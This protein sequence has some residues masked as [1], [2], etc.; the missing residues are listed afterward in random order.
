MPLRTLRIRSLL[1]ALAVC[2]V[3]S[4]FASSAFASCG[5]WLADHS[6]E[7][8]APGG[9]AS[10][11]G[12]YDPESPTQHSPCRGPGCRNAPD[13][14]HGPVPASEL[15]LQRLDMAVWG[16]QAPSNSGQSSYHDFEAFARVLR[17][18][19]MGIEHPP[20]A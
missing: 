16:S 15:K 7:Q 12:S 1:T 11:L 14:P 20:R 6:E 17:G 3:G 2:V 18:Y 5:D 19:P 9:V 13:S 10:P 4:F 8:I